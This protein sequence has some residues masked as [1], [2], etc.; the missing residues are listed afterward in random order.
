MKLKKNS[1]LFIILIGIILL[2]ASMG[3][4]RRQIHRNPAQK[5]YPLL[6]MW[7]PDIDESIN[8]LKK[9]NWLGLYRWDNIQKIKELKKAN[10]YQKH[11]MAFSYTETAWKD[12]NDTDIMNKIPAEWFLTQQGSVLSKKI[13]SATKKIFVK[14]IVTKKGLPLFEKNDTLV[15][16]YETMKVLDVNIENKTLTVER[17]FFRS[18]SS[19][20]KNV[21]I[22]SQITF[23][24]K[25]W[26]MNMSDSCPRIDVNDGQC[27][28][29][30]MEFAIK[31][32]P[33][34]NLDVWDGFIVDR[35][36]ST[37]SWLIGN[38]ISCRSIDPNNSNT[39]V[40]DNYQSFDDSWYRGC[41]M[42]LKRLRKKMPNKILIAN[43]AGAYYKILN[44]TI[45][46]GMPG[47]WDNSRPISYQKWLGILT[48]MEGVG[49]IFVS[50]SGYR[51]NF[52]LLESYEDESTP[53]DEKPYDNPALKDGYVPNYQ[54]MR[55]GLT[56]ALLGDGYFSYE[57]NT[58]GH[59][60]LGLFWFDEYDN[61]GKGQ[62][63]L[64]KPMGDPYKMK[65]KNNESAWVRKFEGGFVIC[66]PTQYT[67]NIS[68]P[69]AYRLIRGRQVP[70][71][72]T[73]KVVSSVTIEPKDGRILLKI[74]K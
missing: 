31:H 70:K 34:E 3:M 16:E 28:Q 11:F 74:F 64:G 27:P 73:G 55:L 48:K 58:Q 72:N 56:S 60:W 2:F 53:T 38:S 20:K 29:T 47:N 9:Y 43:T 63:Y 5:S 52:S 39:M 62:G 18:A 35:V 61:A 26:V 40:T 22:A 71:I 12:W 33:P 66:N 6:A 19:H 67:M 13:N 44:G 15:C 23:W 59:G 17:G 30:W 65:T 50:K 46:E 21:R 54:K 57:M 42:F 7:W 14:N 69:E 32:F 24:P 37:E 10:K 41:E 1:F 25:T 4:A 68:L 45:F 36:E 8:K 51:P 49:Y